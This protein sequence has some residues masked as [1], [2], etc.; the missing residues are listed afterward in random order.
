MC[1][2]CGMRL[3]CVLEHMSAGTVERDIA[4]GALGRLHMLIPQE[5]TAGR[6]G[7]HAIL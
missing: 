2:L 3:K 7:S 1:D 5:A 6:G 4:C